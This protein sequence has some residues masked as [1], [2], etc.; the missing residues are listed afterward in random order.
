MTC[1]AGRGGLFWGKTGQEAP[2]PAS[3]F[4][5]APW[6][7]GSHSV[8]SLDTL[9]Q[10]CQGMSCTSSGLAT[11]HIEA[12]RLPRDQLLPGR[13]LLH[14]GLQLGGRLAHGGTDFGEL[15]TSHLTVCLSPGHE[16]EYGP[17][18]SVG[19]GSL[20]TRRRTVPRAALHLAEPGFRGVQPRAGTLPGI[21]TRPLARE[22]LP[23]P[24]DWLPA[25]LWVPSPS[26]RG[27]RAVPLFCVIVSWRIYDTTRIH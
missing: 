15:L 11:A 14:G 13:W 25:C 24:G 22:T 5:L 17:K 8:G 10:P 12:P 19:P 21:S 23:I 27:F 20:L 7:T 3:G 2:A 1:E 6:G 9:G 16:R 4:N 18:G 26:N